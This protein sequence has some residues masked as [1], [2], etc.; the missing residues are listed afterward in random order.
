M[1]KFIF[2]YCAVLLS[3]ALC[4]EV[5]SPS[6]ENSSKSERYTVTTSSSNG[7][8]VTLSNNVKYEIREDDR[9]IVQGW[10]VPSDMTVTETSTDLSYPWMI[11]NL[12]TGSSVHAKLVDMDNS[13]NQF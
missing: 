10:L 3:V 4:A 8:Y 7:Q 2:C 13:S 1:V 6:Q 11:N 12:V 9:P 5:A